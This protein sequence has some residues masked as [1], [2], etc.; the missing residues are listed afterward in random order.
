MSPDN[1]LFLQEISSAPVT[2]YSSTQVLLHFDPGATGNGNSVPYGDTWVNYGDVWVVT[3]NFTSFNAA[4]QPTAGVVTGIQDESASG[5][6][7]DFTWTG[8]NVDATEVFAGPT[9]A[10]WQKLLDDITSGNDSITANNAAAPNYL[11][12][13]AGDDT[14][15]AAAAPQLN[16]LVGGAGN[17]SIIGGAGFNQIN[18]NVGDDTIVGH[19]TVGD[20]LSGGQGNDSIDASASTGGNIINGNLGNDTIVGGSGPDTLLGGQGD[21]VIHAGS[22]AAWISGDLGNNTIY[23]G[24]GM[25]TFHASGGHDVVNGW[26][27]GDHVQVEQD[28][29]WQVAQVGGDVQVTF[30]NGGE[31]DLIGVQKTSLQTGWIA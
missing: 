7:V 19:S 6:A 26:H 3:G 17:D 24:Q 16:T 1:G 28:V 5:N 2:S 25:D 30:S 10:N 8:L 23:G 12:G 14:L 31:I 29:T 11:A 13:G 4:G 9:P 22:G 27:A 20:W 18:G 15:S 21:D